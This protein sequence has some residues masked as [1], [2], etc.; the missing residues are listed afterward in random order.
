MFEIE[1]IYQRNIF[2]NLF[3]IVHGGRQQIKLLQITLLI[4]ANIHVT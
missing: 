1:Q 3:E 4:T 2:S